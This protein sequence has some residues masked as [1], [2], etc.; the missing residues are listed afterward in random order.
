MTPG[1]KLPTDM[2]SLPRDSVF[3]MLGTLGFLRH[4]EHVATLLHTTLKYAINSNH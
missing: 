4:Y 1:H 3:F 2:H